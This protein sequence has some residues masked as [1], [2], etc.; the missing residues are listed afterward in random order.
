MENILNKLIELGMIEDDAKSFIEEEKSKYISLEDFNTTKAEIEIYKTNTDA[1]NETIKN[2]EK[3]AGL[4]ESLKLQ[5]EDYKN[6]MADKDSQIQKI[7]YDAKLEIALNGANAKNIRAL[8]GLLDMD[9]I[10]LDDNGDISGLE[11]QLSSLKETDSY[12]F[13]EDNKPAGLGGK[14]NTPRRTATKNPFSKEHFN[15]TEQ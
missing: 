13:N 3:E 7:K 15:I 4:S 1:L 9:K 2:L 11:E 14:K 10:V 6:K 8:R 12:L 5:I